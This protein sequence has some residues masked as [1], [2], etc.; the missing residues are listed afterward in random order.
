MCVLGC[1]Q[2]QPLCLSYLNIRCQ[3]PETS[4]RSLRLP[5]KLHYSQSI[6]QWYNRKQQVQG[7]ELDFLNII[8]EVIIGLKQ[9]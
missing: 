4:P 9:E 6:T 7:L 3:A 2:T 8:A 5:S 1:F